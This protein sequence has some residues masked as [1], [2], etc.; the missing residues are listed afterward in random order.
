MSAVG[1]AVVGAREA[2]ESDV[3]V[4]ITRLGAPLLRARDAC[5]FCRRLRGLH[6]MP[7]LGPTDALVIRPCRAVQTYR[8]PHAIDLV[9]LDGE[10]RV[11]RTET[12]DPGR[13]RVCP[14]A[15][16]AIEM[17]SGTAARLGLAP[18]HVL[19][20]SAGRWA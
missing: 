12:V 14:G 15:R 11:L 13:V 5:T 6:A 8:M 2:R 1:E 7:P 20:S 10:G 4:T 16:V 18:G 19:R 9:F 3:D 17:A